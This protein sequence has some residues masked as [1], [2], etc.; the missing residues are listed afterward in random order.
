MKYLSKSL[1]QYIFDSS[2]LI[3]VERRRLVRYLRKR[4]NE[5]VLPKKVSEEVGQ[6]RSPLKNFLD[7]YPQVVISFTSDEEDRYLEVRG[8][9]GIHDGEAAAITL[10]LS[11][12]L[13][14]VI[15]DK[16]GRSK[17]ENHNIRC[18]TWQ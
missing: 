16:K 15:G 2:T 11:R 14:L 10:A 17:A 4:H 7:S 18:L 12:N 1:F 6:P 13:P 5:I 9:P 3:D 8:Q